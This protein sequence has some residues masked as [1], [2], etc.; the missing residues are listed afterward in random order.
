MHF[1]N[2]KLAVHQ[3]WRARVVD[4]WEVSDPAYNSSVPD[5]CA[6]LCLRCAYLAYP[7]HSAY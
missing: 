4:N 1:E 6:N 7:A 5:F 3:W 2:I